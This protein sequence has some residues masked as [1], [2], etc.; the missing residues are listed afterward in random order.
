MAEENK[1]N[2]S[3]EITYTT[4][5]ASSEN[6]I[7]EQP[8]LTENTTEIK[9]EIVKPNKNKKILF[10]VLIGIISL[11]IIIIITGAILYIS[12][13][14]EHKE[15]IVKEE[16]Q[17][18][19]SHA[20]STPTPVE[21]PQAKDE[22]YKFNIRDINSKKL[23]DQLSS[24]TNKNIEKS[25]E[26][27]PSTEI[28]KENSQ[29]KSN[30]TE[31]EKQKVELE[32]EKAELEKQKAELEKGKIDQ[33]KIKAELT[34]KESSQT[35]AETK[36][37]NDGNLLEKKVSVKEEKK[38]DVDFLL[39]INVV[40][41]KDVLYKKYLDKIMAINPNVKLCRDENNRIEIYYGPFKNDE[42]RAELLDK[43]I[44]NKFTEAY[45]LEFTKVE[46]DKRCN[47]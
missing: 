26:K 32:K 22:G 25:E 44:K 29:I 31:L 6:V 11:L 17:H 30:E 5:Q 41:I 12:G 4:N 16:M 15:E 20:E 47:Y 24:L 34:T 40:K 21:K 28:K 19:E 38:T 7:P 35:S 45:A 33:E 10:K 9:E 2:D 39:F 3:E 8:I 46:F 23:N 27:K 37:P 42:E 43:L 14:F 36:N 13:F 18:V 1:T